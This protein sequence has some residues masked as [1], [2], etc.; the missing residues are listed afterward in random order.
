MSPS[1]K[2]K[3]D[4]LQAATEALVLFLLKKVTCSSS[5]LVFQASTSNLWSRFLLFLAHLVSSS[6]AS[7]SVLYRHTAPELN[8]CC[9]TGSFNSSIHSFST[10]FCREYFI[11]STNMNNLIW[12]KITGETKVLS[13]HCKTNL[14]SPEGYT[15]STSVFC[16]TPALCPEFLGQVNYPHLKIYTL[17]PQHQQPLEQYSK[18]IQSERE[19][20]LTQN[21]TRQDPESL[22]LNKV[23]SM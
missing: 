22:L 12:H 23:I 13:L 19:Q 2:F 5:K 10:Q 18:S 9:L 7:S 16:L 4:L 15:F 21:F 17:S 6:S 1:F 3:P 14:L 11:K 20:S 8:T